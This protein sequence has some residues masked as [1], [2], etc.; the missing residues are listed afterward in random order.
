MNETSE[1]NEDDETLQQFPLLCSAVLPHIVGDA[2]IFVT[3]SAVPISGSAPIERTKETLL[4][5]ALYVRHVW[6]RGCG[7][8]GVV[9]VCLYVSST[10]SSR[11]DLS[12]CGLEIGSY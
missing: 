10:C 5:V 7:C 8:V 9:C 2:F 4:F 11:D 1:R 6:W 12:C 3:V